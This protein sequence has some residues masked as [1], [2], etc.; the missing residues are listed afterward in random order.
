DSRAQLDRLDARYRDFAAR[1]GA[2]TFHVHYDDYMSDPL[3]LKGLYDWLG[4]PFEPDIIEKVLEL[5]H[6]YNNRNAPEPP[7]PPG[8]WGQRLHHV[9]AGPDAGVEQ[10]RHPV[11]HR[12]DYVRQRLERGDLAVDLTASVVAHDDAVKTGVRGFA[13]ILGVQHPLEQDRA[14]PVLAEPD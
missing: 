11:T 4:I 7:E 5:P 8:S 14:V 13:R 12:S 1:S 3:G 10:H 6:S 2:D 9:A